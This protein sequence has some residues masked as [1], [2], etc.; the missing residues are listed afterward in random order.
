M[1]L[2]LL[3]CKI[4]LPISPILQ[5]D[6][7]VFD[8]DKAMKKYNRTINWRKIMQGPEMDKVED[9]KKEFNQQ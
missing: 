5:N 7:R 2:P 6:P 3:Y 1:M 9:M 4:F 8:V